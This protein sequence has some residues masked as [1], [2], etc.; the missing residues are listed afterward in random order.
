MTARQ[1][2]VV[3]IDGP[4]GAGKSTVA[5]NL[6]RALAYRMLDTGAIYRT[7]ALLAR[8]RGV[9]WSDPNALHDIC[10]NLPIQFRMEDGNNRV[11][12]RA[13]AVD[14]ADRDV[15]TAIREPEIS[16]GASE[17]SAW[18]E[19]RAGLLDLQRRLGANGGV[20]VE[21]RDTGTVVFP[22]A[23]AKFFLTA[24]VT[25]RAGRRHAELQARG[26]DT[27]I[28][29]IEREIAARDERDRKR[30]VA[31]LTQADDAILMDSS[32]MTIDEVVSSMLEIVRTREQIAQ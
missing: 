12:V 22:S 17:V 23:R 15:S 6:A 32:T 24:S 11:L 16:R 18:P 1:P 4:A 2:I 10:A 3:T 13:Q 19:V 26:M 9:A 30:E 31:P 25:V 27:A 8:E 5:K 20:V 29:D 21:G 28:E 7:V 14:E